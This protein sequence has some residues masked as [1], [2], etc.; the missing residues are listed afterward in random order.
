MST[1]VGGRLVGRIWRPLLAPTAS[2]ATK[3]DEDRED[4]DEANGPEPDA[5]SEDTPRLYGLGGE[6]S[7]RVAG[8]AG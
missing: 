3:H 8:P 4:A 2:A 1:T 5:S 7:G 6:E